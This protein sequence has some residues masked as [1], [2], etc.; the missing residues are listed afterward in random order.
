MV[1]DLGDGEPVGKSTHLFEVASV[2]RVA[3]P[4]VHAE[5]VQQEGMPL[6]ESFELPKL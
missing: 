2:E 6:T 5:T 3:R 1:G 4:D